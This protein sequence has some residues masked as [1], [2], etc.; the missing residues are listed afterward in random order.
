MTDDFKMSLT[1]H[2]EELRWRIIK[3]LAAVGIAFL[4]CYA[5]ADY[6]LTFLARPLFQTNPEASSLIGTG[7]AE[8]FFTKL[9][10]AFIAG[11]FFAVP[12]VLYQLWQFVAPG[13]YQSEK[14]YVFP[15]VLFGSLFSFCR[16]RV[17]LCSGSAHSLHFFSRT[18][19]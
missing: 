2:L 12:I 10:V 14:R 7:I 15:F 6:L 16:G 8:A 13:L 4:P 9:K 17:L 19:C 5:F 11:I 3:S 18:I 1:S